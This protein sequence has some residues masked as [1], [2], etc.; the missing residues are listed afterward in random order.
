MVGVGALGAV[1]RQA[2]IVGEHFGQHT[3]VERWENF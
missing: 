1:F 2:T 3:S